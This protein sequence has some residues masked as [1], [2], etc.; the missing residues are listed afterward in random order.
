MHEMP[1]QPFQ[2]FRNN[3]PM[4]INGGHSFP[5]SYRRTCRI[6]ATN[7]TLKSTRLTLSYSLFLL[8]V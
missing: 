8:L 6:Q 5:M 2:L 7:V 1:V 3:R 4:W